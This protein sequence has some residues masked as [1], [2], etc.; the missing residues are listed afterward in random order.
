MDVD[1]SYDETVVKT[2]EKKSHKAVAGDNRA[3][4]S[5]S[6]KVEKILD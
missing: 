2:N 1:L 6:F 4:F 5:A 3:V